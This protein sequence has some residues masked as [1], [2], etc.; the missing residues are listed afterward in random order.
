MPK[1][2]SVL[3]FPLVKMTCVLTGDEYVTHFTQAEHVIAFRQIAGF[4][5]MLLKAV[6]LLSVCRVSSNVTCV[7]LG[8]GFL[9]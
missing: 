5:S 3:V 1:H 9:S 6:L 7:V 8:L 4:F 2:F